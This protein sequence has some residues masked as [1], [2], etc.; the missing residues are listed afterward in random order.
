MTCNHILTGGAM[1][2]ALG[3][4]ASANIPDLR[5]AL[6]TSASFCAAM[7]V[8]TGLARL[9]DNGRRP[10]PAVTGGE[11]EFFDWEKERE[12]VMFWTQERL[13]DLNQMSFEGYPHR[14]ISAFL[15]VSVREVREKLAQI[16]FIKRFSPAAKE[17]GVA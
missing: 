9:L 17:G 12:K 5:A 1:L 7:G 14:E 3:A 11:P 16:E 6:V 15:G 4:A 8:M 10:P 13:A 2:A